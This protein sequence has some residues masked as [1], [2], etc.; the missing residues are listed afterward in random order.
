MSENIPDIPEGGLAHTLAAKVTHT[1]LDQALTAIM[2]G[3]CEAYDAA[4]KAAEVFIESNGGCLAVL[5]SNELVNKT[6]EAARVQAA[7]VII[8]KLYGDTEHD[9]ML[10]AEIGASMRDQVEQAGGWPNVEKFFTE[11]YGAHTGASLARV[12][13]AGFITGAALASLGVK[14]CDRNL[15]ELEKAEGQ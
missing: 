3:A 12:D 6:R 7:R 11:D 1:E 4:F 15:A 5:A 8:E 14:W 10:M 2:D 9:L 13:R